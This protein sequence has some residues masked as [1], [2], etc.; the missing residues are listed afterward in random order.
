MKG[1]LDENQDLRTREPVCEKWVASVTNC[2]SERIDT[3]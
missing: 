2:L 1:E 3:S